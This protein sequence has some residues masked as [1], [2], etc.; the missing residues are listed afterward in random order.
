MKR[1]FK[2]L[3]IL[4]LAC[5]ALSLSAGVLFNW[6]LRR[7]DRKLKKPLENLTVA[8][9]QPSLLEVKVAAPE[10]LLST[11]ETPDRFRITYRVS[12]IPNSV[13]IAFAQA[14]QRSTHEEAFLM[15]EPGAWPWNVGDAL[16]DGLPRRRL[17]AVAARESLCLVFYEHGG[18]AKTDDI[19]A[20]RLS[21][22]GAAAIWHSSIAHGV[23][24]PADLRDAIRGQAYGDV[25][26]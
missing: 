24:S 23:A 14:T 20:F 15:A 5:L 8:D 1:R 2:A 17:K 10:D 9:D 4:S 3:A 12:D 19:A 7:D 25:R 26:Y 11:L 6:F 22:D 18:I 21:G 16:L 13:K